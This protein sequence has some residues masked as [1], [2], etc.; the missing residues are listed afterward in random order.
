MEVR[1]NSNKLVSVLLGCDGGSVTNK[2]LEAR[3]NDMEKR[4]TE[5]QLSIEKRMAE[6]QLT[7]QQS[8]DSMQK[9][10]SKFCNL[11]LL[12]G[13]LITPMLILKNNRV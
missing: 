2:E 6:T 12:K 3:I 5:T 7:T 8:L 4:M 11:F 9:L 10:F 1:R 13:V